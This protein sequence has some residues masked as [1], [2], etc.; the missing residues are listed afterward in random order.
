[1]AGLTV[2]E[3]VEKLGD[4]IGPDRIVDMLPRL[5]V[6]RRIRRRPGGL[7][8]AACRR[9]RTVSISDRAAAPA[10]GDQY[11]SGVSRSRAADMLNDLDWLRAH[12]A[13]YA[14]ICC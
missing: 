12:M 5:A 3:I 7:T 10:R 9:R 8:L 14:G 1:M 11:E 2:D 13:Q 6:R 4:A